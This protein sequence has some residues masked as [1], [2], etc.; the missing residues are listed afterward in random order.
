MQ[1]KQDISASEQ[2]IELQYKLRHL[3][4]DKRKYLEEVS[5]ISRRQRLAVE[6]LQKENRDLKAQVLFVRTSKDGTG[7]TKDKVSTELEKDRLDT[8]VAAEI[9]RETQLTDAVSTLEKKL[10]L[11]R[12]QVRVIGGREGSKKLVTKVSVNVGLLENR[13]D[14]TI[15]RFNEIIANNKQVRAKV[16]ELRRERVTFDNISRKLNADLLGVKNRI[17]TVIEQ[18][19]GAYEQRDSFHA[20]IAQMKTQADREHGEFE[21]EW[22]E[23]NRLLEND[24]KMKQFIRN[25]NKE[26]EIK[27]ANVNQGLTSKDKV[28][29]NN[30]SLEINLEEIQERR[31]VYED[32]FA[33]IQASTGITSIDALVQLFTEAEEK[34]FGLYTYSAQLAKDI[35]ALG[36][37]EED[38]KK[39][40]GNVK[41][42]A[43]EVAIRGQRASLAAVLANLED[44]ATT[45]QKR[46]DYYDLKFHQAS[47]SLQALKS[48]VESVGNRLGVKLLPQTGVSIEATTVAWLAEVETASDLLV[49]RFLADEEEQ[50]AADPSTAARP[51]AK[52]TT[53]PSAPAIKVPSTLDVDSASEEDDD[54]G[55]R[56]PLA[57]SE[58]RTR[59][60]KKLNKRVRSAGG[61]TNLRASLKPR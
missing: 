21:K 33:K 46:S 48:G 38:L 34:S 59:V 9:R 3:E 54:D 37:Q 42:R 45:V 12:E 20:K 41:R 36:R 13:L 5:G 14:K 60:I 55:D 28:K 49:T 1:L 18:A 40:L 7:K 10:G 52:T 30:A 24:A 32:A 19:N 29:K 39:D 50:S 16:D 8:A 51:K 56:R 22:K 26:R 43:S 25:R 2:V 58:I 53:K 35:D 11:V 23:L 31:R 4:N 27:E 6:K 17:N 47:K 57:T 61:T 15:Q 44:K